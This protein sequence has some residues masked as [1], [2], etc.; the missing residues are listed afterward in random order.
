M[1]VPMKKMSIFMQ[2]MDKTTF[3]KSLRRLGV[4]HIQ[5]RQVTS[6]R[7][8]QLHEQREDIEKI[9]ARIED[10]YGESIKNSKHRVEEQ[11]R[12]EEVLRKRKRVL[13]TIE[14][15]RRLH[16][17]IDEVNRELKRA[18]PWGDFSPRQ[19]YAIRDRGVAIDLYD[20]K[21]S[22]LAEHGDAITYVVLRKEKKH[23]AIAVIGTKPAEHPDLIRFSLPEKGISELESSLNLSF[24]RLDHIAEIF[25]DEARYLRSYREIL[26][27][28]DE[29]LAFEQVH[30]GM[31]GNGTIAWITGFIP[32]D[33]ISAVRTLAKDNAWGLLID[34]V[35]EEDPVPT[36]LKNNV[37]VRMI[38][39]I[40]DI[41]GTVPGYREYDVSM[42]FLIFFAMFF[43]M[44]IGD[45]GYGLLFLT[46][47]V[48]LHAAGRKLT[49]TV[50][51]LYVLSATTII[52]G[53]ATG[54]WF[55]SAQ[56]LELFRPLKL[57]VIPT[58]AS[59]PELF[60]DITAKDTQNTV[61][62]ICFVLGIVQLSIA[63]IVNFFRSLPQI[64]AAAQLGWL[65][66][67][68]GLYFLVLQL[69][70]GMALPQWALYLMAVGFTLFVIFNEQQP[71]RSFVKGL[72]YGLGGLFNT[73][74]DAIG[75]FS[76]I[77][78][79]IRLFAVGMASVA[80]ATSFNSMAEPL[81]SGWTFPAA[82]L[83]LLLGHGL[84]LVMG[85]LSVVVHGIRLNML[86]FSG[87]LGMEWTGIKYE[88]FMEHID[89]S[90]VEDS[91]LIGK[92]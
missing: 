79:Y 10:S 32:E 25:K 66:L 73:F 68:I 12:I 83:I 53:A 91:R 77:I 85:L 7:I 40:F 88:P 75:G 65:M 28:I 17:H 78:S 81:L 13:E 15:E 71:G 39:P 29:E 31:D 64:K 16:Q 61:M 90:L 36:K 1:I 22:Y 63:C 69:V 51:L 27:L 4:M 80:I 33:R 3:L 6:E 58:I 62:F 54:T 42:F 21:D 47:A 30:Y 24:R 18:A 56:L 87:Q 55:G 67:L 84:N 20:A 23:S 57:L 70:I 19:V 50:K 11:I 44:I 74:L 8:D 60:S 49:E 76:N 89:S 9:C 26:G 41:L 45:A 72:L 5:E 92:E 38:Q 59:F 82:I 35:N 48:I 2:E 37:L 43:A 14:E 86:E 52:W 34:E 46:G